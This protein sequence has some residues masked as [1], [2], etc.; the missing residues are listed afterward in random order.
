MAPNR[1]DIEVLI[2]KHIAAWC[3]KS[4]DGVAASYTA[5]ATFTINRGKP[6]TGHDDIAEMVLGFCSEFPDVVLELDHSFIAGN[7]AVYVW[8]FKGH[9]HETS[10]YVEFRGWEEWDLIDDCLVKSSLGWF[11]AD[12]YERQLRP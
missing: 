3:A 11:D 8:T 5:D 7:H 10:K 1:T 2:E 12:D 6:M 4:P 9:H